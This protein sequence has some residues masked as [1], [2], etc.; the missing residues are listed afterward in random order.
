MQLLQ[1]I[2]QRLHLI[3][4]TQESAAYQRFQCTDTSYKVHCGTQQNP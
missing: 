1:K 3:N 2:V 4:D